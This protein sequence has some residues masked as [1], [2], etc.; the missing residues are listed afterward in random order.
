MLWVEPMMSPPEPFHQ[1]HP[2]ALGRIG[3][4]S[5]RN[6]FRSAYGFDELFERRFLDELLFG[7]EWPW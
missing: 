5:Y 2:D 1:E 4:A 6:P 7:L 3:L